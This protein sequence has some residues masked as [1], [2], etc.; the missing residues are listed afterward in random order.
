LTFAPLMALIPLLL[1]KL[2]TRTRITAWSYLACVVAVLS[3]LV[4]DWTNVYGIRLM[5]PFSTRWFHLDINPLS[6]LVILLILVLSWAVPALMGL[7]GGEVR[8]QTVK[9]P[10]RAWAWFA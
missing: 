4:L 6:E 7:V 9:T 8:G 3:H 1:V 5:L 2:F 10:R